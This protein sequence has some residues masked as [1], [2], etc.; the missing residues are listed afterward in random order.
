M[1]VEGLLIIGLLVIPK[2]TVL[3]VEGDIVRSV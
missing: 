2:S 1:D 3:V